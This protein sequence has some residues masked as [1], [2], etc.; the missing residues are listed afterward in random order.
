MAANNLGRYVWLLDTIRRHKRLT[1]EE[2][3]RLWVCSGLSYGEGDE[4]PL[5]TFHNHR[6][7]ISAIFDVY[8]VI[9]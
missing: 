9:P 4:I 5:R 8:I 1:F 2:I 6:K 7:A 3:N